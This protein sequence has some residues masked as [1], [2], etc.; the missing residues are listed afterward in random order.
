MK[1]KGKK[2]G[3]TLIELVIVIA[4]ISILAAI[5]IPRYQKSKRQA[6]ITAHKA[7]VSMLKTAGLVKLNEKIDSNDKKSETWNETNPGKGYVE[8]WPKLPSIY[9]KG[10]DSATEYTV[11]IDPTKDEVTVSPDENV[12]LEEDK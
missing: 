11:T 10:T 12:T 8:K 9:K 4:I 7:N 3:F 6:E 1:K 5:A 2:R